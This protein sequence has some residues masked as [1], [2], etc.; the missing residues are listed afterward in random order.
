MAAQS[1]N[2]DLS[3]VQN[4]IGVLLP[5]S[6]ATDYL[7]RIGVEGVAF[8]W[9]VIEHYG[10]DSEMIV[11]VDM[12]P[13]VDL[14]SWNQGSWAPILD[15]ATSIGSSIFFND[16][17]MR[18]VSKIDHF[19]LYLPES[20]PKIGYIYIQKH[21]D[22]KD[23][24]VD[25]RVFDQQG[26]LLAMI[27]AMRLSDFINSAVDDNESLV[28]QLVWVPPAFKEQPR[29]LTHV[30]LVSSDL[31][32]LKTYSTQL[33]NKVGKVTCSNKA[34]ELSNLSDALS[35]KGVIVVYAPPAIESAAQVAEATEEF[36]WE[37]TSI[38]KILAN[39]GQYMLA[40]FF[41]LTNRVFS[42]ESV[43]GLAHGALY[44]L[45]RIIASEHPDIW[46]GLIDSESQAISQCWPL[47]TST[48]MTYFEYWMVFP[49][50]PS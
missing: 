25:I 42:G 17:K 15:A 16:P 8:P 47:S 29:D 30:I 26:N 45:A 5:N 6:F 1:K 41:V 38:V 20:P 31:K 10:N 43:T 13:S 32:L 22:A 37:T 44:G 34:I 23:H 28:H 35:E 49:E 11:K 3:G 7:A 4:R 46:G 19:Y 12:D 18:I 33:E 21:I 50:E 14:L 36:I 9:E 2:I 24:A 48:N 27:Q 39:L 40:K